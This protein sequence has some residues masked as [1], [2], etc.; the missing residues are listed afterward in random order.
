MLLGATLS[1]VV[2]AACRDLPTQPLSSAPGALSAP[3]RAAFDLDASFGSL[4]SPTSGSWTG[5]TPSQWDGAVERGPLGNFPLRTIVEVTTSGDICLV[6]GILYAEGCWGPGGTSDHQEA[7]GIIIDRPNA[8]SGIWFSSGGKQTVVLQDQAS[9]FRSGLNDPQ[10]WGE[11]YWTCG[12][13]A[14]NIPCWGFAG[15][16]NLTFA[17]IPVSLTLESSAAGEVAVDSVVTFTA[18]MDKSWID[19]FWVG[20]EQLKW[21]WVPDFGTDTVT[22][23]QVAGTSC[24]R[25]MHEPGTMYATAYVNGQQQ[26]QSA[27]V[28][29]VPPVDYALGL[30]ADSARVPADGGDV[31]LHAYVEPYTKDW[32]VTGWKFVPDSGPAW[33]SAACPRESSLKSCVEHIT[34]TGTMF[35][36]GFVPGHDPDSSWVRL[37]VG[38][39]GTLDVTGPTTYDPAGEP[40]TFVASSRGDPVFDVT[41]WE[42]HA[43]AAPSVPAT[44]S[45]ADPSL[46]GTS[47]TELL[48]STTPRR[49][50]RVPTGTG[51]LRAGP[52]RAPSTSS[53]SVESLS[54]LA[55][56]TSPLLSESAPSAS[57][58]GTA[59]ECTFLPP[60]AGWVVVTA[61]L[62]GGEQVDSV[63][64]MPVVV[65]MTVTASPSTVDAGAEVTFTAGA[66]KPSAAVA[67]S[68]WRF[69]PDSGDASAACG[70]T[71]SCV[72]ALARSGSMWAFGS[73]N[74]TTDSAFAHVTVKVVPPV[75]TTGGGS[76]GGAT[77][78]KA[79]LV[80]G[81]RQLSCSDDSGEPKGPPLITSIAPSP[82]VPG[83]TAILTGKNFSPTRAN[84][85][86]RIA[87][88]LAPVTAATSRQL[89]V[90]V[91]CAL[92]DS[93]DVSVTVGTQAS[94]VFRHPLLASKRTLTPGQ[95]LILTTASASACNELTSAGGPARYIVSVFDARTDALPDSFRISADG[96]G[97]T[98]EANTTRLRAAA[99][100]AASLGALPPLSFQR[101]YEEAIEARRWQ[102]HAEIMQSF[103]R[104][105]S[106]GI[107]STPSA[108]DVAQLSATSTAP[109]RTIR[110]PDLNA[111]TCSGYYVV[112]ARRVYMKGRLAIYEDFAI[113]SNLTAAG[114]TT[115][116]KNYQRIG[117]EFNQDMEP[118]V[119]TNF[120]KV[121]LR[122][123]AL[124]NN[125][126]VIALITPLVTT[127]TPK[128]PPL[129]F[130]SRCDMHPNSAHPQPVGG[131]Y[132][133]AANSYEASNV[134]EYLYLEAPTATASDWYR[135][136]RSTMVHETKHVAA[137]AARFGKQ[138]E[139]LALEEGMA[140]MAEELWARDSVDRLPWKGNHGYGTQQQP[141]GVYCDV[142]YTQAACMAPANSRRP[143]TSMLKHFSSLYRQL[144]DTTAALVSPFE[145]TPDDRSA[146]FYARSWSLLRYALDRRAAS[147]AQFLT[148]IT[149]GSA[150][151]AANLSARAGTSIDSLVGG[152]A[153]SVFADD[154]PGLAN[155]DNVL[156]FP[157]WNLPAV[158]AGLATDGYGQSPHPIVPTSLAFGS[159]TP[160][161][162]GK[163]YGGGARWYEFSGTQSGPQ[164]IRL[165]GSQGTSLPKNLRIAVARLQ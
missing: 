104:S 32:G 122:D 159:I 93:V 62:S 47:G 148:D 28:N 128:T 1:A 55:A 26:Q 120:G 81:V 75:D 3:R 127:M 147:E 45:Q 78:Q 142:H 119:S 110:V 99:T 149:N 143:A 156:Q 126:V 124:D 72:S 162:A 105:A 111:G 91:P 11:Y 33:S 46:A 63:H 101:V 42:F 56:S 24:S 51:S 84:D 133:G 60:G 8:G 87:G 15:S 113:P 50:G 49:P 103:A 85:T 131:P 137:N 165:E 145:Q 117:D 102:H 150:T 6:P 106:A 21:R 108:A 10:P 14:G 82:I 115:M 38:D 34:Q 80:P 64:T 146:F 30:R 29:M 43:D 41:G 88:R 90:T 69:V 100:R 132:P 53:T 36:F 17:R 139:T 97:A 2:F 70:A 25:V 94:P 134:G 73:V 121:L 138:D 58:C 39:D 125:G 22:C 67:V 27:H 54:S 37:Y 154:Y 86:V 71:T 95:S 107:P 153:L 16:S 61:T 35:V 92:S 164:L 155:P 48:S 109:V 31:S 20:F 66:E 7:I 12:R 140:R 158:F 96:V 57:D 40:V 13:L 144:R 5:G 77:A 89:T 98:A 116:A 135:T 74:G 19:G 114:D 44:V 152:W 79:G 118:I 123:K 9:A 130:A 157:T 129:G 161:S 151:G 83:A 160:L 68:G 52:R 23:V 18:G 141:F 136:I 112:R 59:K 65:R 76:C 163:I 4:D